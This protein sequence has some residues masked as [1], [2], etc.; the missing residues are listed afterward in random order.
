MIA[1]ALIPDGFCGND[2]A[3]VLDSFVQNAAV[4]QQDEPA[5]AHGDDLLKLPHTGRCAD[6]GLAE[7]Q[8]ASPVGDLVN[9]PVPVRVVGMGDA[10]TVQ[11]RGHGGE[12][13]MGKDGDHRFREILHRF[14]VVR[15]DDGAG[16]GVKFR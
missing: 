16:R 3:A 1:G 4:A 8:S 9:G 14:Y 13:L 6:L 7:A 10:L 5:C 11:K 15:V 12:K 2:D